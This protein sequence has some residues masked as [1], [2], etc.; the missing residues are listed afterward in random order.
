MGSSEK[1]NLF[2]SFIFHLQFPWLLINLNYFR[3]FLYIPVL[4][5]LCDHFIILKKTKNDQISLN[6]TYNTIK[7]TEQSER[8]RNRNRKMTVYY[9]F[10]L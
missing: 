6:Q 1:L 8:G 9:Q 5:S 3:G 2:K 4:E 7:K 10:S